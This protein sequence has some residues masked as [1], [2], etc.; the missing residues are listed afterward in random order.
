MESS[1]RSAM[2]NLME[3]PQVSQSGG[4]EAKVRM[5]CGLAACTSRRSAWLTKLYVV[6]P[7]GYLGESARREIA[8]AESLGKP[9]LI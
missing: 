2:M 3:G 4:G 9:V 7:E 8:H 5:L 1:C 6:D